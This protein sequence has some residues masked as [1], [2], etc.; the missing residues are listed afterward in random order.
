M[1]WGIRN[2]PLPAIPAHCKLPVAYAYCSSPDHMRKQPIPQL[3]LKPGAFRR[4][5]FTAVGHGNKGTQALQ[6]VHPGL[7][8]EM[9]F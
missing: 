5:H 7:F 4:H 3:R 6:V 9:K 8:P 1:V 2:I